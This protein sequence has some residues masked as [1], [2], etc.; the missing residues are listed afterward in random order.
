[1]SANTPTCRI[2]SSPSLSPDAIPRVV[3]LRPVPADSVSS[4]GADEL[5]SCICAH[6][7]G[8]AAKAAQKASASGRSLMAFR[9]GR[10]GTVHVRVGQ[11]Q[12]GLGCCLVR[13]YDDWRF[14]DDNGRRDW[15]RLI[16]GICQAGRILYYH[17]RRTDVVGF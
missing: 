3:R 11:V 8:L 13:T 17:L 15:R 2:A 12:S 14:D 5:V 1:M 10:A 6:A 9:L 7:T 4:E 16:D